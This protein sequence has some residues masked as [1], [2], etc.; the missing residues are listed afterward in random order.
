M[1]EIKANKI[2]PAIGT[3]VTLGDSGDTFTIP[4]GVTLAGALPA[5]NLTGTLPAISGA[6]LT[7]LPSSVTDI[8]FSAALASTHSNVTGNGAAW[9]SNSGATWSTPVTNTGSGFNAGLFTVPAG[10]AGTYMFNFHSWI[11]GINSGHTEYHAYF[12]TSN[13]FY[14]VAHANLYSG[15]VGANTSKSVNYQTLADMDVGDTCYVRIAIYNGGGDC[16]IHGTG[17]FDYTDTYFQ[18][19]LLA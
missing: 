11:G 5:A 13:R 16:D 2:S 4:A 3:D 18:G 14:E 1:S 7:N 15:Y 12:R 6:S 10:G 19:V 17:S 9:H 8:K